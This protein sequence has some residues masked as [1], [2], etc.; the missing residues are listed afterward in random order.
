MSP[1]I[2]VRRRVYDDEERKVM[3]PFKAEYM[4]TSSPAERKTIAQTLL[5]PAL[6]TYW[7]RIG[8]DLHAEEMNKRSEVNR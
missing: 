8:V 4:N 7:S 2:G 1:P 3:D 6:F 5:F